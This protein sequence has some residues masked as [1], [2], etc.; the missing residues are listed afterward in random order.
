MRQ[1]ILDLLKEVETLE[2]AAADAATKSQKSANEVSGGLVASYS[3][4]GDAEHSRNSAN[5]SIQNAKQ[6]KQLKEEL[7]KALNSGAPKT[8][9][10]VCFI[11]VVFDTG[12]KKDLYLVENPVFIQG[13][14]L[15]STESPL[16]K[17]L[18]GNRVGDMFTYKLEDRHFTGHIERVE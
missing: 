13:F 6:L 3:A 10:P 12:Y 7:E 14:N 8:I 15:I 5:L 17:S 1:Q 18:E 2:S 4:A 9:S 16:G 11:S